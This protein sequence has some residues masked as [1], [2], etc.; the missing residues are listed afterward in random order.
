MTKGHTLTIFL[1]GLLAIPIAI[2]GL[3]MLVVGIIPASMW[4]E[5]AFAA[6]YFTVDKQQNP[7]VE[8]EVL[9]VEE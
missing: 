9:V 3:L 2:L 6:I 7:E 5:G 4:I 1:I 8:E